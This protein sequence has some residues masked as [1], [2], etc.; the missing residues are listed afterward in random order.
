VYQLKRKITCVLLVALVTILSSAVSNYHRNSAQGEEFQTTIDPDQYTGL[1]D[2]EKLQNALNDVPSTGANVI[3]PS[4][5]Y[6]GSN[7]IVPSNVNIIGSE[8]TTF[9]LSDN[10]TSP[11][12]AIADNDKN[13]QIENIV[14]D[15]NKDHVIGGNVSLVYIGQGSEEIS[16]FNN[17]FKNF[18]SKAIATDWSEPNKYTRLIT[19]HQNI[20]CNGEGAAMIFFGQYTD[21]TFFLED[22]DI[23]GNK[24]YN[25]T[26]N[27]KIGVAF[28][29]RPIIR[30][31]EIVSCEAINTGSITIRG[32]KDAFIYHNSVLE[33]RAI[34]G[35]YVE[36]SLGF[37]NKGFFTIENNRIVGQIGDG[38]S[39]ANSNGVEAEMA[40]NRNYF[41]DNT[42]VDIEIPDIEASVCGNMVE[43]PADLSIPADATAT[44]NCIISSMQGHAYISAKAR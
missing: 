7:L 21:D 3:V 41:N 43:S 23:C 10:T 37:P 26:V 6:Q 12:L 34:A 24:L 19:V 8:G 39:V 9:K 13:V 30:D 32:C 16:I 14:F 4:K 35:I 42:G 28:T 15:G 33:N 5:I 20:F 40:V 2:F 44:G 27:G 18:R 29:N 1:N 38:F 25:L 17:T 36:T 11:F 31:N 22:V